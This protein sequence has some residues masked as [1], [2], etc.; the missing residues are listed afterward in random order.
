MQLCD[1]I[2]KYPEQI[3][4][5]DCEQIIRHGIRRYT[6]EVGKLWINLADYYIK[7][8]LFEKVRDIFEEAL[9]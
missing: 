5:A 2:S 7:L 6:D 8:G 3:T 1:L 4:I 9:D